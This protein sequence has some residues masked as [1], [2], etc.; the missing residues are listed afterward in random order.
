M[1]A[2]SQPSLL[3]HTYTHTLS[4][5]HIHTQYATLCAC[6]CML[7][8]W[9]KF[10]SRD[11]DVG[12]RV[13]RTKYATKDGNRYFHSIYSSLFYI[14][15]FCSP[16]IILK[17]TARNY[18]K[19][20]N[21]ASILRHTHAHITKRW[22]KCINCSKNFSQHN[23]IETDTSTGANA[24]TLLFCTRKLWGT[25]LVLRRVDSAMHNNSIYCAYFG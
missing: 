16:I 14:M 21:S 15:G 22:E 1:F 11:A 10:N 18:V 12:T 5:A 17:Y 25:V 4:R 13:N 6:V 9:H 23:G 20:F 19:V 8:I 3:F 7:P 24:L 2:L